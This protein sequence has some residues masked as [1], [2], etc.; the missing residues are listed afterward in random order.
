MNILYLG[1]LSSNFFNNLKS[2]SD[3]IIQTEERITIEFLK[4]ILLN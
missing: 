2:F 4:N 1:P 3:N